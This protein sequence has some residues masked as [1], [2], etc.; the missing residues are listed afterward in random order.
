[1]SKAQPSSNARD[2]VWID[3]DD[4]KFLEALRA[5]WSAGKRRGI[6]PGERESAQNP[7]GW[8]IHL[9]GNLHIFVMLG[10]L[11]EPRQQRPRFCRHHGHFVIRAGK[12]FH[13]IQ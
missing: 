2:A 5:V 13:R 10:S 11:V 4:P 7:D 9:R 3:P 6:W 8:L 12:R 1:M